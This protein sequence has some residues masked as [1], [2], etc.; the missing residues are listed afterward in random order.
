MLRTVV[1]F[2]C[3]G[4][5]RFDESLFSGISSENPEDVAILPNFIK[6][7]KIA[8]TQA[9]RA[10]KEE[11]LPD[12]SSLMYEATPSK[13]Q[14]NALPCAAHESHPKDSHSP[15]LEPPDENLRIGEEGGELVLASAHRY[16]P[17]HWPARVV[18][19]SFDLRTKKWLYEVCYMDNE[20][21]KL[22]RSR[23]FTSWEPGFATCQVGLS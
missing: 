14:R 20:R 17:D 11:E 9:L 23:F 18:G 8:L 6:R 15:P 13:K 7:W 5:L 19:R 2:R 12:A 1:S 3:D 22:D 21:Q 16:R 4:Q 10:E